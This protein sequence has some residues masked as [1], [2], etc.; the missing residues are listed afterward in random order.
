MVGQ[1]ETIA[2]LLR[3]FD[4]ELALGRDPRGHGD[5]AGLWNTCALLSGLGSTA[6]IGRAPAGVGGGRGG[7]VSVLP[8]G[9]AC[10]R[11]TTTTSGLRG[12]FSHP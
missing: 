12:S 11:P 9:A 10:R 3:V 6:S 8:W 2:R 4:G 1:G 7:G 5:A